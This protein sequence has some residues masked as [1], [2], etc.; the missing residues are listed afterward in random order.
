[1]KFHQKENKIWKKSKFSIKKVNWN[2]Y[3][4]VNFQFIYADKWFSFPFRVRPT[5]RY[6]LQMQF[7]W[8]EKSDGKMW[9][10][11]RPPVVNNGKCKDRR[12]CTLE[13]YHDK[14]FWM[15]WKKTKIYTFT[16]HFI[17]HETWDTTIM[18]IVCKNIVYV[19]CSSKYTFIT[20][21]NKTSVLCVSSIP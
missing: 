7:E 6:H 3:I 18:N 1:M 21:H 11:G 14:A 16:L 13:R 4:Q 5:N 19:L 9:P 10:A 17:L 20:A 15:V 8:R 12:V 2:F